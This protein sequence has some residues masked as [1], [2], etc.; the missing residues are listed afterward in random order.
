[1]KTAVYN[2]DYVENL[3]RL[4]AV[5]QAENEDTVVTTVNHYR[6]L[7]ALADVAGSSDVVSSLA[8]K[9]ARLEAECENADAYAEELE[10]KLQQFVVNQQQT[11]EAMREANREALDDQRADYEERLATV[12]AEAVKGW[13]YALVMAEILKSVRTGGF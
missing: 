9:I 10:N 8:Q 5:A 13:A 1:M 11:L 7:K 3:E 2:V 12:A 4:A 6:S